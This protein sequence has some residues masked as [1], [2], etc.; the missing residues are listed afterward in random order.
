MKHFDWRWLAI[1]SL[2]LVLAANAET[3]PQYGGTLHIATHA[4]LTSLDPVDGSQPDSF[5]RRSM[6][7]LMFDTLIAIDDNGRV[8]PSLAESWQAPSGNRHWEFELRNRIKFQDGTPLTAEIAAASLHAA[9]PSWKV[10]ADGDA[11]SIELESGDP[12]LPAELA[13]P[14][15]AI[16][17]RDANNQPIGTG[18][19][20]VVD[21][22]PGKKLTLR[23][24]ENYWGGRPFLDGIEIEMG[25][26]FR[27]QI[28]AY[29]L[30]K[31]DLIEVA[32]EQVHRSSLEARSLLSS[33]L[34]ELVA[35]V[36]TR[37]A[38]SADE[39]MMRE[40]LA[41]SIERGSMRNALLQGTGQ[42]AASV[43]PTW[44]SGYGFVFSTNADLQSARRDCDQVR[45]VTHT[46][47]TWTLGYDGSDPLARLLADRVALN[48]RDAGLSLQPTPQPTTA[49]SA[50][51]RLVRIPLAS[52]DPWVAFTEVATLM[53]SSL[54]KSGGGIE[55][56]FASEQSLLSM[57]RLI[58]LFH[59]PASYATAGSL[60][61][62][63]LRPDGSWNAAGA[64]LES[65]KP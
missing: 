35:L 10:R 17:K 11:I 27:D 53:G 52:S 6:I 31:V 57:R 33:G 1:S 48:A 24:E 18:P 62:L 4:V 64:W 39:K 40:A 58:P 54:T 14:R 44:L 3:R 60:N 13:L 42:P 38:N 34:V 59:L 32:P 61:G 8:Q 15:N 16:E 12:D 37:D 20:Q 29:Q 47:P 36:F 21:W 19:Y 7:L 2:A 51:L 5:A 26:S 25:K 9:N 63:T 23:A 22:A 43:L 45:A 65:R 56:L 41:L 28:T 55:D 30:G 49:A 46:I 50:D